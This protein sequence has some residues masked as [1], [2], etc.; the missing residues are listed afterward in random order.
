MRAFP[1]AQMF[2]FTGTPIFAENMNATG[3]TT[4]AIF[5]G[6]PVHSY[7][8][9]DAINAHMVL[10]F[11]VQYFKTIDIVTK[12]GKDE[13]VE[14]IDEDELINSPTRITNIS[15][16]IIDNFDKLTVNRKYNAI[17]AVSSI[18]LLMKYYDELKKQNE[19][20]EENQ[21]IK[22]ATIFTYSPNS[23]DTEEVGTN[24][25]LAQQSLQYVMDDYSKVVGKNYS[26]ANCS[27]YFE[28]VRDAFREGKVELI[29]VVNMMLT[30]FDSKRINTLFLDKSLKYHGL[31]QA[32]SR[33]N[34]LDCSAKQ[35]GNI[36][37]Y[38]TTPKDVEKAVAL[39]SQEDHGIVLMKSFEE[40]LE[41]FRDAL[42]NLR[43]YTLTPDDVD[44]LEGDTAKIEFVNRFRKVARYLICLQNF[45]EF[46]FPITLKDDITPDEYNS[47]K[48][49]YLEIYNEFKK[50]PEK[51]SVIG[52]VT[53]DIEL[54]QTDKVDVDYILNLLRKLG[55]AG[56]TKVDISAIINILR[57]STDP[58][59][60]SKRELLESFITN[61][62]PTLTEGASV[63]DE[64]AKYIEEKRKEALTTV[65]D[66]LLI[67]YE[68]LEKL[69]NRYD[70]F[71]T[72][73]YTDIKSLLNKRVKERYREKHPDL[74]PIK[75]TN[76][77]MEEIKNYII[78]IAD[79][80]SM[81][82]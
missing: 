61:V 22:I 12:V 82:N 60:V 38:R 24:E 58:I 4:E 9:K 49:R 53:F 8:I 3:L 20:L 73:D 74:N 35:F 31:I 68:A 72:I 5:G 27:E 37:C 81:H 11:N 6:K 14:A 36:V 32:F 48:S 43:S 62:F 54:V 80:Y 26:I 23:I 67:S 19:A 39:Y 16:H 51:V 42:K 63:D 17:F 66:D 40:Y 70:Y 18:D 33:T 45:C 29:L 79:K 76:E 77:L 25:R 50:H 34:R 69:L 52:E 71:M 10:G 46:S 78:E 55:T 47:F 13:Q 7:K 30:G 15:K 64:L 56:G 44:A 2:G 41:L 75:A 57:R 65:S 59:L 28:D 21:K 1:S